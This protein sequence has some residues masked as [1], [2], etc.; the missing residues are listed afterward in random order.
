MVLSEDLR[1]DPPAEVGLEGNLY[2]LLSNCRAQQEKDGN[3]IGSC[4][5]TSTAAGVT[6]HRWRPG[7]PQRKSEPALASSWA[8]LSLPDWRP[9]R[10]YLFSYSSEESHIEIARKTQPFLPQ[11]QRKWILFTLPHCPP[12]KTAAKIWQLCSWGCCREEGAV[13][14]WHQFKESRTVGACF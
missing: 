7:R 14:K 10:S 1:K 12:V 3:D 6:M 5:S 11:E 8:V 13:G 4:A 9:L 2:I